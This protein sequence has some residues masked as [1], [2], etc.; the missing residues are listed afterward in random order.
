MVLFGPIESALVR[1]R[2]SAGFQS[3]DRAAA[4]HYV[5]SLVF[6]GGPPGDSHLVK[7]LEERLLF[8][9]QATS[10][11]CRGYTCDKPLT[12]AD[13]LSEQLESAAKTGAVATA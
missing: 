3:L 2:A 11:V 4:Q 8:D 9:G 5:P 12:D 13:A 10:Y 7:L 1:D 6:A